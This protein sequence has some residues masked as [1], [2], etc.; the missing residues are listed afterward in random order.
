MAGHSKWANIKHR[1]A[2]QDK[3]R[4]KMWSKCSR[5]I[6]VAA[7]QGG[8]DPD[9]NT[10]LR[11]AIDDAKA[12]NMPKDTIEKAIK[13]GAGRLE[14]D[15]EYVPLRFEGYGPGGVAIIIDCLTDNVN[16]TAPEVRMIFDKYHGNLGVSGSVAFGFTQRGYIAISG[17]GVSEEAILVKALE[18]GAEDVEKSD[19]VWEIY[20][21]PNDLHAVRSALEG[22]G[23]TIDSSE[24]TMLANTFVECVGPNADKIMRLIEAFEDLDDVQKVYTNAQIADDDLDRLS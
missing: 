16:R 3:V 5:A 23:F 24:V 13:K 12:V 18:A 15:V 4:G 7:R 2:R 6:I 9:M 11:Y 20:T 10:S 19:D 14:G 8:S 21:S 17:Q 22:A 1:K